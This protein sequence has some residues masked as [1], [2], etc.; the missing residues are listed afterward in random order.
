MQVVQKQLSSQIYRKSS[1]KQLKKTPLGSWGNVSEVGSGFYLIT[2]GKLAVMS[3]NRMQKTLT[4]EG[5]DARDGTAAGLFSLPWSQV[6][7]CSEQRF[8]GHRACVVMQLENETD[9]L[10]LLGAMDSW[11]FTLKETYLLPQSCPGQTQL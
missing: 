7:M 5:K 9:P 6:H 8:L 2:M 4:L 1:S 11:L 10:L 3:T